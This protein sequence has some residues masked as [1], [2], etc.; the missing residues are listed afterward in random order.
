MKV[1]L[2]HKMSGLTE[3]EVMTIRNNA[4]GYLTS[5]YGEI[6]VIDN[7]HHENVPENAGRLWHLG[8]S[9]RQMEEADAIYFCDMLI[10]DWRTAKGCLM[11]FYIASLY[12]LKI[13]N[14]DIEMK[15]KFHSFLL[16]DDN[17]VIIDDNWNN[18]EYLTN[19]NKVVTV[20]CFN[21][22]CK[23]Q[24]AKVTDGG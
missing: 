2:S 17:R 8:T 19:D 9:I 22:E 7:Y 10:D 3:D 14:T 15:Q 6:E 11:E 21:L 20:K 18:P 4:I 5:K 24:K 12:G 23:I 16:T 13:L 1:F